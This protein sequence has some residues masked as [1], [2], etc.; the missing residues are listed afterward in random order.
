MHGRLLES[1][2]PHPSRDDPGLES[3]GV[4]ADSSKNNKE[5]WQ[6]L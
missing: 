3:A 4:A 1:A 2:A 5:I 6:L